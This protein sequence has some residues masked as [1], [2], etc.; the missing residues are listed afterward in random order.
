MWPQLP[1]L[2]GSPPTKR[3]RFALLRKRNK[4][5]APTGQSDSEGEECEDDQPTWRDLSLG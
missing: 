5:K 1:A 2:L 3:P 4:K